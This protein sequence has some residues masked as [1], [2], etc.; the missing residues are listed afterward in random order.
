MN[1]DE[2]NR[3]IAATW[4]AASRDE[5][6]AALDDAIRAAARRAVGAGPSRARHMRTWPLAAAA[7]MALFAVGLLQLTPPEQV[8]PGMDADLSLLRQKA[9]NEAKPAGTAAP[10]I[11]GAAKL[12]AP[13][14][15]ASHSAAAGG[16]AARD[17][18]G[19]IPASPAA[20]GPAPSPPRASVAASVTTLEKR[21]AG[22]A[23]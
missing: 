14:E 23:G 12:D 10:V 1:P 15:A 3:E 4:R 22:V 20:S 8:T 17:A 6:P 5:P 9:Q 19:A 13:V 11:V 21:N 7:V 16:S 18:V 2:S